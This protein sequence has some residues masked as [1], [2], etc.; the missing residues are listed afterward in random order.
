MA[1]LCRMRLLSCKFARFCSSTPSSTKPFDTIPGP[2]QLPFLGNSLEYARRGRNVLDLL[3][4]RVEEYGTIYK[5]KPI[6]GMPEMVVISNSK[7]VETV[8]RAD[9]KYPIRPDLTVVFSELRHQLKLDNPHPILVRYVLA[10]H[11]DCNS[12]LCNSNGEDWYRQR[13]PMSQ[14]MMVPRRIGEYHVGFNEVSQ[15]LLENVRKLRDPQTNIV[16]DVLPL[17][18]KWSFECKQTLTNCFVVISY[19]SCCIVHSW[20]KTGSLE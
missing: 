16:S 19:F 12:S 3:Q 15:D 20:Q 2:K 18:N 10:S 8:F 11:N 9:G 4:E 17:L 5:D 6:P 13:Q 14:F 1:K 7:D